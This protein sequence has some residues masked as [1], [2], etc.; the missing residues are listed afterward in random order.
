MI[1]KLSF[2][3]LI[4]FF[5]QGCQKD[6]M[7]DCFKSA[8]KTT[9]EIRQASAFINIDLSDN[10][11]LVIN[12]DTT[13]YIKV[14]AGDNLI[15]GIITELEGNTLYIRNENRC[16]WMRSFDN[17]YIVEVGMDKPVKI[18]YDGSGNISCMDTIR[19]AEFFFECYD[20][21]GSINFLFNCDKTYL[22]NH[23]G[24]TEIHAFGFSRESYIYINDVGILDARELSTS[25]TYIRHRTTGN[26]Y[27]NAKDELGFEIRSSGNVYYMGNPHFFNEVYVGSGK[28][29]RM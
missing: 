18:Y 2:T 6:H 13:P 3:L 5:L 16:N 28:V 11:D 26:C 12:P 9:T 14:T 29:I 23:I 27:V 15:E 21:S 1:S 19:S 24:R 25:Y 7:L 8:G 10:V 4:V 20:G 22:N 17:E